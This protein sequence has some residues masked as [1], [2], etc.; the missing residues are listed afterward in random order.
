MLYKDIQALGHYNEKK[1]PLYHKQKL[2]ACVY[3]SNKVALYSLLLLR[4][5]WTISPTLLL[6]SSMA[7][8]NALS[9]SFFRK[10]YKVQRNTMLSHHL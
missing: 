9:R 3:E 10:P 1:K 4:D 5:K 7:D 6:D 8:N 2:D